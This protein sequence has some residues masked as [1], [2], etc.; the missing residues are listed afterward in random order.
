MPSYAIREMFIPD[1]GY[2]FI[3]GDLQ[4][5]DAHVVAWEADDP[6]LKEL[7]KSGADIHIAN[8]RAI[9][10]PNDEECRNAPDYAFKSSDPR[11]IQ[12]LVDLRDKRAKNG[13]HAVNYYV[14]ARTLAA[15]LGSTIAEAQSFI[16]GWLTAHPGVK[17]WHE[18]TLYDLKTK[19][20]VTNKFGFRRS[21]P[22]GDPE[23]LLPQA[24][25]WIGQ[26]TVGI[27]INKGLMA[28]H[29][30]D[31]YERLIQKLLQVHDSL[32]NQVRLEMR[33]ELQEIIR[34]KMTITIPYDDPLI[35]PV[36]LKWSDKSWEDME[37][38]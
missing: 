20:Y 19:R 31:P 36:T 6:S 17:E 14:R 29:E 28:L 12:R 10:G 8:A 32:L 11:H 34:E 18:R 37:D 1:P 38:C 15:T 35:I 5:A 26:S 24:L 30:Y 9:Y 33:L 27:C 16:D 23:Q 2:C 13:V 22:S 25:A 21:Y 4:R 7:F 3:E